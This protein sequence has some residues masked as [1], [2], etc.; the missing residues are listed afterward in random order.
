MA[1]SSRTLAAMKACEPSSPRPAGESPE[2][3]PAVS[4]TNE[5]SPIWARSN[6]VP[7]AGPAPRPGPVRRST[8]TAS[9]V[10]S[11][12]SRNTAAT[13]ASTTGRL[14]RTNRRSSSMPTE[15]KK[16]AENRICSGRISPSAFELSRDSLTTSPARKAPRDTDTPATAVR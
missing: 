8:D 13:P 16:T 9:H 11:S 4:S 1:S 3:R 7:S 12:L 6:A 10:V 14:A 15:T 2:L 5:N